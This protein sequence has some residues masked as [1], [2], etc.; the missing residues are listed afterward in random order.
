MPLRYWSEEDLTAI[1]TV[2]TFEDLADIAYSVLGRKP[3]GPV[4]QVCGPISTGGFNC[5]KRNIKLFTF[6]VHELVR[7]GFVVNNQTPLEKAIKRLMADWF[8][9]NPGE[10]YCEPIL[11]VVYRRIFES[12]VITHTLFLPNWQSSFGTNWEYRLVKRLSISVD[13]YPVEWLESVYS[14]LSKPDLV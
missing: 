2:S 6:A 9:E 10:E 4:Y 14:E 11:E 13:D 5:Q 3:E 7:R 12:R 1:E 8:K